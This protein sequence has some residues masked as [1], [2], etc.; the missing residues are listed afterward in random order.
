[1][2]EQQQT[3]EPTA[4]S[5]AIDRKF[6]AIERLLNQIERHGF[7]TVAT[8]VLTWLFLIPMRDGHLEFL[9]STT[10][11]IK[12]LN[13][14]NQQTGDAIKQTGDALEKTAEAAEAIQTVIESAGMI[15]AE[16][17][18]TSKDT[19]AIAETTAEDVKQIKAAVV[20]K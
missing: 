9:H 16:H 3:P 5:D 18:K 2:A 15:G 12:A 20:P 19:K 11:S 17:Y 6:S 1:M 13:E 7:A 4:V 10:D 8:C 14:T